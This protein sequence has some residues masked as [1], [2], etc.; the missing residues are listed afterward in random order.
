MCRTQNV[1]IDVLLFDEQRLVLC[2]ALDLFDG[3]R[4][5]LTLALGRGAQLRRCQKVHANLKLVGR[6]ILQDLLELF[7][8]EILRFVG[9]DLLAQLLELDVQEL[10][11]ALAGQLV[12]GGNLDELKVDTSIGDIV[13]D[14]FPRDAT[15]NECAPDGRKGAK[16]V[17][18]TPFSALLASHFNSCCSDMCT[19]CNSNWS[20]TI[21][22]CANVSA[23]RSTCSAVSLHIN[24]K[25]LIAWRRI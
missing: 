15:Q 1:A 21:S 12:A 23:M 3:Q 2:T 18:T 14:P 4:D 16:M 13:I 8:E 9:D 11:A 19:C 10:E 25:S 24:G 5:Q 22:N 17:L 6:H 7:D 20:S